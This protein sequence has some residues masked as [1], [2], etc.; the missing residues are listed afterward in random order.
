MTNTS[1]TL[2]STN[3]TLQTIN[4]QNA[5]T[6]NVSGGA[7]TLGGDW[8]NTGT[9]DQIS[10]TINLGNEFQLADLGTFT[11]SA[12]TVNITGT[13]NDPGQ[14]LAVDSE[15]TWRL[16]GGAIIGVTIVD[17]NDGDAARDFS[18]K[19]CRRDA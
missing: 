9:I 17:D 5:G 16:A 8:I 19:L 2:T 13:L 3:G 1:G 18:R 12:G 14:T 7:L 11:G 15:R 6:V 10:G 4:L